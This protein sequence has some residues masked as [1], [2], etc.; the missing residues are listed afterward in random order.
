MTLA[1]S[2]FERDSISTSGGTATAHIQTPAPATPNTPIT[3]NAALLPSIIPY[4][5]MLEAFLSAGKVGAVFPYLVRQTVF[6]PA[7]TIGELIT[8]IP[9]GDTASVVY[10]LQ[11][12]ANIYSPDFLVSLK[13]DNLP[14]FFVEIPMIEPLDVL[15]SFLVPVQTMGT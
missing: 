4:N 5:V 13:A 11:L 14:P 9:P 10:L 7:G 15:G 2:L 6:V 8:T 1:A 12:R 3:S